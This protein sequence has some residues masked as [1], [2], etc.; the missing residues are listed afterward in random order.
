MAT[1][2]GFHTIT[3][4]MIFDDAAAAFEFYKRAFGATEISAQRDEA[5]TLRHG[6][7]RIGDSAV[8]VTNTNPDY[9]FIR[10]AAQCGGDSPI[11]L[12][13]YCDDVDALFR[14]AVSNGC[15]VVMDIAE[16]S[17]GR[18]GGVRDPFGFTWWLCTHKE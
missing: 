17:Y 4:Y 12:F 9:S 11:H 15:T 18:S 5:G 6:E 13:V 8:M 3:P 14:K 7:F 10:S 16:Q 2:T 1:P